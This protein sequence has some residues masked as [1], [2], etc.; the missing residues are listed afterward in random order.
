MNSLFKHTFGKIRRMLLGFLC[1]LTS[2]IFYSTK[3]YKRMVPVLSFVLSV[4]LSIAFA[5]APRAQEDVDFSELS[6][7][8][9]LNVVVTT[10]SKKEQRIADAAAAVFVITQKDIRRS[11]ATNLAD[12]LRMAPGL[13]VARM[14]SHSWAV[15]ARG[16][17]SFFAN[18]LLVLVDRRV[19]YTPEFS[20]VFWDT[21]APP[22]DDI[23]RI[24]VIRGPGGALWGANAVNGVINVITKDTAY[25]QGSLLTAG[26]GNEEHGFARFRYGGVLDSDENVYYRVY[27]KHWNHDDLAGD[28]P[29]AWH[30]SQAGFRMDGSL[31]DEKDI[32]TLQGDVYNSKQDE[33]HWFTMVPGDGYARGANLLSRWEHAFSEDSDLIAQAYYDYYKRELPLLTTSNR[34]L[35]FELQHS[36][37][38]GKRQEILWGLGYR[39]IENHIPYEPLVKFIPAKLST[40]LFSVF[41]Q[42][43]IV[44]SPDKI[45]L[46]LG[47]KFE[48]NDYTGFEIQPNI[49]LM[50]TPDDKR[51]LWAAVS[52]TVSTPDRM[53]HD[54]IAEVPIPAER[55]PFY[56]MPFVAQSM[57]NQE[58][59]SEVLL[60]YEAGMRT[61][62]SPRLSWD[63]AVFYNQYDKLVV[64][65]ESVFPDPAGGRFIFHRDITNNMYGETY[66]LEL[67][68]N[69]V[70]SDWW[71]LHAAY[72]WFNIHLHLNEGIQSPTEEVDRENQNPQQ[73][74][75]L[76]SNMDFSRKWKLDLWMRYVDELPGFAEKYIAFDARLA[77]LLTRDIELSL[78]GQ[79]L[80]DKRHFEFGSDRF[81][82][83]TSEVERSIYAQMRWEF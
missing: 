66:G 81:N 25:T 67:A 64:G 32:W 34:T 28:N 69:R 18:K 4:F 38:L 54:A 74:L 68:V 57:G 27:G 70:V 73:Q 12:V 11:G 2:G 41:L 39:R 8:E 49:R 75:S 13:Q 72:T 46:T 37:T 26:G 20:G 23:A 31:H 56:P 82:T 17:N 22:L 63:A 60:T 3:K 15:T 59:N 10:V 33:V 42:D 30:I 40:E 45:T 36:F 80:F 43:E 83:L 71:R 50:F 29:D 24:E 1:S 55:N 79:N 77:W 78:V 35:D 44:L 14:N 65:D 61:Q 76:R 19:V 21:M 48:Y 9:L 53:N 52:R 5:Q 7:E 62:I 58:L 16:F 6:L 47:S 51:S